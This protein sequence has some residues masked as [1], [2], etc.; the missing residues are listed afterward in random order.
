MVNQL[1][2]SISAEHNQGQQRGQNLFLISKS[3]EAFRYS[4]TKLRL[5]EVSEMTD[6]PRIV[7]HDPTY[8]GDIG[9][10]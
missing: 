5:V 1:S 8:A 6:W 7:S 3:L 4:G 2:Y 10:L 9:V